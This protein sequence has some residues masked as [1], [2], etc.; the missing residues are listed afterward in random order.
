MQQNIVKSAMIN[1]LIMGVIFSFNFLIA[2]PKSSILAFLSMAIICIIVVMMYRMAVKFRDNECEGT[3]SYGKS[4]SY[5]ILTFFFGS[6]IAALVKFIYAQFINR[7]FPDYLMQ[8]QLKL[9]DSWKIPIDENMYSQLEKMNSPI[10]L[11]AQTIWSNVLLGIILGLV[12]AFFVKK[13]KSIFE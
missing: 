10:G 4:L 3:I 7:E 8:V 12:L 13:E 2:L 6:L 5:I 11:A 1:G 9:L